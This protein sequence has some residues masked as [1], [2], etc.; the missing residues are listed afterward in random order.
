MLSRLSC[1]I[2]QSALGCQLILL[3]ALY[4]RSSASDVLGKP[5]FH[6]RPCTYPTGNPRND[7]RALTTKLRRVKEGMRVGM[8]VSP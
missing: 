8:Q 3:S 4:K 6:K 5:A 7:G 2:S 1:L